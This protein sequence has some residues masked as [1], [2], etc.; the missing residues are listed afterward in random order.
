MRQ[1]VAFAKFCKGHVVEPYDLA[2]LVTLARQAFT[3]GEREANGSRSADRERTAF[4]VKAVEMRFGVEWNGL[5]P[6]LKR[7]GLDIYLPS[8]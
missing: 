4:E 5:Y 8:E 1:N 2:E 3:A 7:N 6:T